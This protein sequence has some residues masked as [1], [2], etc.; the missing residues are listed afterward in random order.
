MFIKLKK[1]F[2]LKFIPMKQLII[3]ILFFSFL[4][5]CNNGNDVERL[6][7][8][9]DSLLRLTNEKD[10]AINDF[11]QSFNEI[12]SNLET[13]KQKEN[14]I[15]LKTGGDIEL[16]QA[17]KDK[18]NDDI[19]AIYELMKKNKDE[20]NALKSKL[21]KANIKSSEFEKMIARMTEQLKAKDEEINTLK[22]DLARLNIDIENLNI[23]IAEL[24]SQMD[25]LITSNQ[26]KEEILKMQEQKLNTAYFVFGT[27][28]ELK[29]NHIITSEG[30]FIGIGK[31]QKLMDDFNKDYFK[32]IDIRTTTSIPLM[33]KKAKL[34]TSHPANSYY[35]AGDDQIDSLVIKNPE[36]FWS[37]SK[38]LVIMIN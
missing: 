16:D 18:I 29:Q 15:S 23:R 10:N 36:K 17:A 13:I 4:I 11:M 14:I 33:A 12:E 38:Y 1:S 5:S 28:K 22:N 8:E 3:G 27:K 37:V 25:T 24:N 2:N 34:V 6:K 20:L 7:A 30:G 32:T 19:F 35:F 9:R 21:R 26:E 31:M